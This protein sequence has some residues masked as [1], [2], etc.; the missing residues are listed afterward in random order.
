MM[1]TDEAKIDLSIAVGQLA[2]FFRVFAAIS[3][4]ESTICPNA[5]STAKPSTPPK[6]APPNMTRKSGVMLVENIARNAKTPPARYANARS[7][8]STAVFLSCIRTS[9]TVLDERSALSQRAVADLVPMPAIREWLGGE[10]GS[11]P[12]ALRAALAFYQIKNM[13]TQEIAIPNATATKPFP[14]HSSQRFLRLLPAAIA[15]APIKRETTP[16]GREPKRYQTKA[17]ITASW[18]T[19]RNP[20]WVKMTAGWRLA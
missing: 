19:L 6:A 5:L 17:F 10:G 8:S 18:T 3:L 13:K 2:H 11:S 9:R 4:S 7:L 1:K 20:F 15:Q 12:F 16:I 14:V